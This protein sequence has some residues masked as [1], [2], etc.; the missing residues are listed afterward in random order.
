MSQ[1]AEVSQRHH[2]R[3][4]WGLVRLRGVG[5]DGKEKPSKGKLEREAKEVS[6][7]FKNSAEESSQEH[8]QPLTVE[9]GGIPAAQRPW[10]EDKWGMWLRCAWQAC[11]SRKLCW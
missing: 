7:S 1:A 9:T 4:M 10:Q 6:L 11:R 8:Q 2:T 3:A 5:A